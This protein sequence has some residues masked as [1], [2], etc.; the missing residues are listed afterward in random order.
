MTARLYWIVIALILVVTLARIANTHQTFA[1]TL[2]EPVHVAA[3]HEWMTKGR[4]HVDFQH[5]PWPRVLFALPFLS[6]QPANEAHPNEYGNDLYAHQD[7]YIHNVSA[8]R[9]GNLLFVVIAGFALAASARM[10]FGEAAACIALALFM[11]LPPVLAHGGLATTDMAAAAGFAVGLHAL[12]L[13]TEQPSRWRSV[14]LG[15]AIAFG[16]ACK[17]SFVV[18]FAATM[19]VVLIARRRFALD[20]LLIAA[21]VAFVLTWASFGFAIGAM[22]DA[23]PVALDIARGAGVPD[24]L[25]HLTVPAP[26]LWIGLV[27]VRF[28]NRIGHSAYLLG[29]VS[30]SGWWYYFP[31]ALA[32]KTPISYLLLLLWSAAA[33]AAAFKSGGK[34]AALQLAIAMTIL[35]IAM[36]SRINIGIRH[37]LPIYIPLSIVAAYGVRRLPRVAAGIALLW[38]FLS[39]ALAH[40]DYIPWMNAFAGKHPQR[41]LLDSNYDWGQ[42]IWRLARICR[43]RGIHELEYA[44][45]TGIR[46]ASIGIT[47]GHPLQENVP[48]RGWIVISEQMIEL[49]RVKNPTAY[50]WL[51]PYTFERVGKTLRL[52]HLR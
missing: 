16:I 25:S 52:Y 21:L 28:H 45:V 33:A 34:A 6:V 11:M 36:S 27:M 3:G 31:V 51:K 32:F 46:P 13:W 30:E 19:V 7:R 42:D 1:Q 15:A 17:Y 8:A 18:F 48:S 38:L 10:L 44:V 39:S 49:A 37:L 26:D 41:V 29:Q 43:K 22:A 35:A 9:R 5:P 40:P 24:R 20:K 2:D 50:D 23:N 12:L 14:L 4:Y 47:G